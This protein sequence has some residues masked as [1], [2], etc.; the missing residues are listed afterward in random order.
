MYPI[1]LLSERKIFE[2]CSLLIV[3]L[4]LIITISIYFLIQFHGQKK[5]RNTD[6]RI[7]SLHEQRC[8]KISELFKNEKI[9]MTNVGNSGIYSV[10]I[11]TKDLEIEF[12][13]NSAVILNMYCKKDY[14]N[15]KIL[16][17]EGVNE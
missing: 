8:K 7:L 5:E 1:N 6:L 15:P 11:S 17:E 14:T 9:I 16:K 3:A 13:E 12:Q 2:L 4:L 10:A